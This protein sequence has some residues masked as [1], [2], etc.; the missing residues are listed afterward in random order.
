[1]IDGKDEEEIDNAVLGTVPKIEESTTSLS[2]STKHEC[3]T[4]SNK[5]L[6]KPQLVKKKKSVYK[7]YSKDDEQ[8]EKKLND[9][10]TFKCSFTVNYKKKEL[11]ES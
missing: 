7:D 8:K 11:T 10:R 9:K 1:M 3:R 5:A 6:P 2:P 4:T